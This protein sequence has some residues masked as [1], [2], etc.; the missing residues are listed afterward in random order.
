MK[1]LRQGD[2][3]PDVIV[4]IG[5]LIG[6]GYLEYPADESWLSQFGSRTMA[7]VVMYQKDNNLIVDG[8]VGPQTWGTLLGEQ[9]KQAE[10][11]TEHFKLYDMNVFDSRYADLWQPESA[12]YYP[13]THTL[14]Q[15]ILEPIRALANE[16][17]ADGGKVMLML[18]SGYRCPDYNSAIG[19]AGG[20]QHLTGSA[21]DI[22]AVR[23]ISGKRQ[24]CIPTCYQLAVLAMELWPWENDRPTRY[25]WGLGSNTNLHLDIRSDAGHWWYGYKSWSDWA[26]NQV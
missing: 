8:I 1:T 7:A 26:D 6:M 5:L 23:V 18:R 21:A 17:Y 12:L 13:N 9:M 3:G 10:P 19:G 22:Y 20:S 4:L 25:G 16:R 2:K 14:F 24:V 15:D 11:Q